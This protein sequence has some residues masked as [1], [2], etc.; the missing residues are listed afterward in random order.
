MV[1]ITENINADQHDHVTKYNFLS[2]I[3]LPA[4]ISKLIFQQY[5]LSTRC[6]FVQYM[7]WIIIISKLVCKQAVL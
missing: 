4:T 2:T 6:L 7:R 1:S 3:S 5:G